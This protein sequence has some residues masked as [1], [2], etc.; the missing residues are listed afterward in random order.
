[1]QNGFIDFVDIKLQSAERTRLRVKEILDRQYKLLLECQDIMSLEVRVKSIA[2]TLEYANLFDL[3][4][5]RVEKELMERVEKVYAS[6]SDELRME[7]KS[8]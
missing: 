8:C 3:I 2:R 6:R 5:Y 7:N 1:M 4:E